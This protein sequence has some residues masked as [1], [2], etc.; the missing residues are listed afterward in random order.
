MDEN[1]M[2]ASVKVNETKDIDLD[3]ELVVDS[4]DA[5]N[6]M[7]ECNAKIYAAVGSLIKKYTNSGMSLEDAT[8]VAI[9]LQ[10]RAGKKAS[11]M[12]HF[13]RGEKSREGNE[14]NGKSTE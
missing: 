14:K 1:K 6:E 8:A 12:V 13:D 2:T 10:R 9:E 3:P 11:E 7:V 5:I 4:I